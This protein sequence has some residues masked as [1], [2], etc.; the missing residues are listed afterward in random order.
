MSCKP[1]LV[2]EF[3]SGRF[4]DFRDLEPTIPTRQKTEKGEGGRKEEKNGEYI[5]SDAIVES[6]RK[7]LW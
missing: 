4:Y 7:E 1:Q 5:N 2:K 6:Q 3:L